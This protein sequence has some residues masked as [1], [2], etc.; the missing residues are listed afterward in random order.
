[1]KPSQK[2]PGSNHGFTQVGEYRGRVSGWGARSAVRS[3]TVQ[4]SLPAREN[5]PLALHKKNVEDTHR[6]GLVPVGKTKRAYYVLSEKRTEP[7]V[8]TTVPETYGLSPDQQICAVCL[9]EFKQKDE[10]GICPCKHAFHR[11]F[12]ID[13]VQ[14][15]ASPE[16]SRSVN[17]KFTNRWPTA[18]GLHDPAQHPVHAGIKQSRSKNTTGKRAEVLPPLYTALTVLVYRPFM[19]SSNLGGSCEVSGCLTEQLNQLNQTL[20]E[21]QQRL[22]RNSANIYVCTQREP[23]CQDAVNGRLLR[24]K[25]RL[26]QSLVGEQVIKDPIEDDPSE[27]LTRHREQRYPSVVATIQVITF[28][29]PDRIVPF[30]VSWDDAGLP[31]GS[32]DC[33]QCKEDSLTTCLEKFTL[34]TT[35]PCSLPYP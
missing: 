8:G 23:S 27:D 18:A 32:K 26:L 34:D 13:S 6:R 28:S 12:S 22:Q 24:R 21:N 7:S 14:I 25:T 10:L 17:L 2:K 31:N 9:E 30:P 1:M 16:K 15:T 35:D 5:E 11:K 19:I 20:Y 29:F 33:L 3:N 4:T